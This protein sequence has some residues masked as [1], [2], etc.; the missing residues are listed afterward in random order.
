[1]TGTGALAGHAN[2]NT[3][4][5]VGVADRMGGEAGRMVDVHLD[6]IADCQ[7][8]GTV[9]AGAALTSDTNGFAVASVAGAGRRIV[10]FALQPGDS[11]DIIKVRVAP[12]FHSA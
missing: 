2:G 6:G 9:A 8:A 5:I 3:A 11:G 7:L 1:M 4:A 12:G 10:G